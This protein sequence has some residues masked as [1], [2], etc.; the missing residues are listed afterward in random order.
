MNKNI[1]KMKKLLFW[2][3]MLDIS[4]SAIAQQNKSVPDKSKKVNPITMQKVKPADTLPRQHNLQLLARYYGDSVVLRWAPSKATLWEFAN[5]AGYIIVRFEID[6]KKMNLKTRQILTSLPIKPWTLNEW[7]EKANRS[8][9]LAAACAQILYGKSKAQL[10]QKG[11]NK[12]INLKEAL[13]EKYELENRH[14]FALFL[15]DQSSFLASGLGLRFT[16]KN[17]VKGKTYA[18]AIYALTDP[19]IV[20]SDT[21]GVMINTSEVI[22]APEMKK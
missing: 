14:A 8:D 19:K 4:L 12:N 15:A 9:S 16:D 5:K 11:K 17:I 3:I 20:K 2:I 13:N 1:M 6:N 22:P 18:Y 21:S 7:K 10:P